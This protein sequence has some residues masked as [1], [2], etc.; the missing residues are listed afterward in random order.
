MKKESKKVLVILGPTAVGKTDIALK[1]A[2]K[3]NGELVACDSRQLYKGLDIGTGK[4]PGRETKVTKEAGY[5]EIDGVRV[6]M[7]DLADPRDGFNLK[8]YC[9][10]A[11]KIVE[12][13]LE[14]GKLPIIVGGTGLYLRGLLEGLSPLGGENKKLRESLEILPVGELQE[15][16]HSLSPLTLKQ[17]N[18]SDRSNKRR[19]IRK[20]ELVSMYP[21]IINKTKS[22]KLKVQSWEIF[23]VGLSAP[24]SVINSRI[25]SRLVSRVDQGLFEEAKRL[26]QGGLSFKRMRE[27]GLEYGVLAD[28]L[29]E[30]ISQE[31]FLEKLKIKIH[32]YAK[33]QETW[34]KKEKGVNWFDI[35]EKDLIRRVERLIQQWYDP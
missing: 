23:K 19:L 31:G 22:S 16:L 2:K 28:L 29:E 13:I 21:Y 35:T 8:Q 12:K 4:M 27:L 24:R 30:K 18:Q 25:D 11:T 5:W 10:L 34:F 33:R 32:Q 14:K 7:Y 3:F 26:H 15:K 1:L 6:W 9:D 17:M 20:I